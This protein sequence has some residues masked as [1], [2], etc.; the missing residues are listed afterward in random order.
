LHTNLNVAC[1]VS[2]FSL[3]KIFDRVREVGPE[4]LAKIKLIKGDIAGDNLDIEADDNAELVD[5]LDIV[6]HLAAKVKF[7]LPLREALNFNTCGTLRV[8]QLAAKI[9]K[10]IVFTHISTSY[11]CPN[12]K[13]FEERYHPACE[14][15]YKVIKLLNSPRQSDLND[16]EPR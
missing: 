5:N 9:K 10:P 4:R 6:F 1:I 12:E 7:S 15:P 11:C 14:D 3:T 16:V 2:P 8:L 13:I